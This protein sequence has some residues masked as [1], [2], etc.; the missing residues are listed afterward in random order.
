LVPW[1]TYPNYA[2]GANN[3][4]VDVDGL[5]YDATFEYGLYNTEITAAT[6][7]ANVTEAEQFGDVLHSLL[8]SGSYVGFSDYSNPISGYIELFIPYGAPFG[9][10]NEET[11]FVYLQHSSG[12]S[13]G[14]DASD[15]GNV[16]YTEEYPHC[17][18]VVDISGATTVPIPAAVWLLGS[19]LIG[20]VGIRRKYRK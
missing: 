10:G 1:S 5:E 3:I 20:I 15:Y 7:F 4:L 16:V 6:R 12:W 8:V 14:T 9:A 18:A 13:I 11:H 17:W 19:G 2:I